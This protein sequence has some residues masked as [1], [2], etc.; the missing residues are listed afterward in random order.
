MEKAK[1]KT[2]R[3]EKAD[4]RTKANQVHGSGSTK[5][6][7]HATATNAEEQVMWQP[8]VRH[9]SLATELAT[10]VDNKATYRPTAQAKAKEEDTKVVSTPAVVAVAKTGSIQ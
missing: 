4:Q 2:L 8:T 7:P 1:A 9:K 3:K 10:H 5:S 6:Q